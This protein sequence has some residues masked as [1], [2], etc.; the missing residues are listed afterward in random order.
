MT[1]SNRTYAC[2]VCGMLFRAPLPDGLRAPV[3]HET[4]AFVTTSNEVAPE[5]LFAPAPYGH[6]RRMCAPLGYKLPKWLYHCE[7]PMFLLG[8]R[9]SQAATQL[10]PDKRVAWL[11]LGARVTE[12]AG[13]KRWRP[14]TESSKLRDAYPLV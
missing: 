10:E 2:V 11:S 5:A 4:D 6:G 9:A 12:H 7:K 1:V 8:R 14:I 3:A 13:S